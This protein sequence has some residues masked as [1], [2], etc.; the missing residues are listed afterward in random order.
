LE[1]CAERIASGGK[2]QKVHKQA[3]PK[4]TG[5]WIIATGLFVAFTGL[6]AMPAGLGI[7]GD[8]SLLA[9]GESVFAL[10]VLAIA[11]GIYLNALKLESKP[12]P[13]EADSD[14]T[15]KRPRGACELCHMEMPAVHCTVHRFHLCADCL[16]QHYDF[17]TCV[18]VP[19]TRRT[20][21]KNGKPSAAK[22]HA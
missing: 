18:Y 11:S 1:V 2:S 3:M 22:A 10:G 5:N 8:R 6:C 12:G 21:G 19:S 13:S 9:L 7:K 16:A 17:R 4:R 15:K 20:E 14:Q